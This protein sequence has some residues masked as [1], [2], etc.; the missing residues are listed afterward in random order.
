MPAT[1]VGTGD[2]YPQ[3]APLVGAAAIAALTVF[4]ILFLWVESETAVAILLLAAAAVV[5]VGGRLGWLRAG[6][7]ALGPPR[8]VLLSRPFRPAY[9]RD[10]AAVRARLPGAH[11][12]VRLRRYPELQRRRVLRRRGL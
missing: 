10:R 1:L 3:A 9:G 12:P 4:A 2:R 7:N 6:E 11:R 8:G 5:V